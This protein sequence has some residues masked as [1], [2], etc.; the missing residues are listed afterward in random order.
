MKKRVGIFLIICLLLITGCSTKKEKLVLATEAS[1]PPFEYYENGKIVGVDI[2]IA[3]EI[4]N[5]LDMELEIKDVYFDSIINEVKTQKSDLGAAGISYTEERANEVDFS[6]NYTE[7]KQV[8]IVRNDSF[9]TNPKDLFSERIA[10]QLGSVGDSYVTNNLPYATVVREKK[11]LAAIEDLKDYKVDCVVMDE[12]PAKELI[13]SNM[14]ILEDALVTDYYGIIVKKGNS[15]LLSK[16]NEVIRNLKENGKIEEFILV[17][18]GLKDKEELEPVSNIE[19]INKFYYSVIYDARYK[20]ILEGLGN[21]LLIAIGAVILG[22]IIG[23]FL[24][25]IRNIYDSRRK[26]KI[27]NLLAKTYITVIRGT[28]VILQLMIIYYV[29]FK[30]TNVNIVLIGILAFGIN[31]GAYV[32]EIIRAGINSVPIGQKEAGYALGLHYGQVM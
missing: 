12:V 5:A 2:D 11:F 17:H 8:V 7:S 13:G 20:Y 15:E 21:T 23:T 4:A 32:A 10:V 3:K 26:L 19:I 28:P 30:T 24:A 25:I 1:F 16:I 31:S 27:L 14:T 18:T 9:I 29:I 22:I 6:I